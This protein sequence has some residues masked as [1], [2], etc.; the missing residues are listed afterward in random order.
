MSTPAQ[1]SVSTSASAPAPAPAYAP[2]SGPASGPAPDPASGSSSGPASRSPPI[3]AAARLVLLPGLDGIGKRFVRFTAALGERATAQVIR[4]PCDEPLGYAELEA[5]VRARLP[6]TPFVLL[7]ESFS[8][9]LAIRVA[10][11][12][13]AALRGLVL[14]SSFARFP[15]TA[16]R[17]AVPLLA[18]FPVKSLPRWL[19]APL[20]GG[21]FDPRTMPPAA[22]RAMAA[23]TPQV[24]RHRIAALLEVDARALLGAIRVPV[25]VLSARGDRI[26]SRRA[27]R[28]LHAL[29]PRA[30]L[31]EIDGPHAL[32]QHR[33]ERC[34]EVLLQ[35]M[36]PWI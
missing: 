8:G 7:G 31:L 18:R 32:L 35:F 3:T 1:A 20:L 29:C 30:R 22:E 2:A 10:A 6:A 16:P 24:I 9:P 26:V 12:P 5:H 33:P 13:P 28:E 27:S 14:A 21:S 4:Y 23:V 15:L 34:A 19:R 25:L 17:W 11:D 36:A